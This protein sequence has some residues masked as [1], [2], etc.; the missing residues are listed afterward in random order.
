MHA[1]A[2]VF[3]LQILLMDVPLRWTIKF[4][5]IVGIT[6]AVLLV[7]HHYRCGP[8][9]L[10]RRDPERA[11]VP[12]RRGRNRD[13]TQ[14]VMRTEAALRLA[15]PWYTASMLLPSGSRTKAA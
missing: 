2:A 3:T 14:N 10:H 1:S 4:P 11:E 6:L 9:H 15:S 8:V 13:G 5:L 7:S 12:P